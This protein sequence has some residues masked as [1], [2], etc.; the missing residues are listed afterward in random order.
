MEKTFDPRT[1]EPRWRRFWEEHAL[2]RADPVSSRPPFCMVIPPPNI[3]GRLHVGHGLNNTLQDVLARWKRMAG[4]DVL[5]VPGSD[6]ASIATHVMIE[7]ALEK[8]GVTRQQLGREAFLERA[9]AWK[10]KYGG[11]I[12]EQLRRLG[13]SCDW[14][15]E[16]FTMDPGLSRA[17]RE[18]FVRLYEEGLIY[19]DRYLINW[20]PK[21]RTAVSDL[22]VVHREAAGFM[23][24]VSYPLEG[25]GEIRVATTRP[26]TILG[27]VAVAVHPDDERYREVVGRQAILP[28]LGRRIP[29]VADSF[30]DPSFGTGAVKVTPGHDPNDFQ[31]GRRLGLEPIV[32]MD[33]SGRMT[34]EAGPFAGKDRFEC[35]DELLDRLRASGLLV[36]EKE[37]TLSIG[38]CQR[39]DTIVEPMISRQWFVRMEPLA[40]PALEAVERGDIAFVPDN[41]RKTYYEWMRNIRDWCISRQLWWGHRIPAWYCDSCSET[42]VSR[43]DPAACPGCGTAP[44]QDPDILDT[45]FSSGLWAFSTL[46]WPDETPELRRYYPTSVLVTGYDIIF[47]WVARMVMMGL[48]F[49]GEVPFRAVFYNGLVRDAKGEKISKTKGNVIDLF[50]LMDEYGTDPVRFTFAAMSSPGADVPLSP[51][52]LD[53]S[54]AFANKIWNA[55]RFARPHL[56]ASSGRTVPPRARLSVAD[57]WILSRGSRVADE[58]GRAL[59]AYRFDEAA[60]ALYQFTWHEVC[61]WYLELIKPALAE[62]G[63]AADAA[64]STLAHTLDRLLRLLH[65]FMPFL[66]EELWQ[67]LPRE[68]GD[69]VAVAVAAYPGREPALEDPEAERLAGTL[70]ETVTAARNLRATS[71]VP[72]GAKVR[73]LLRPLD[74]AARADLELLR[75]RIQGL[76]RAGTIEIVEALPPGLAAARAVTGPAEI[77][78]PLEGLLDLGAERARLGREMERLGKELAGH[79]AKLS[80]EQ[81]M[82]RAKPEA[83]EKVRLASREIADRLARLKETLAQLGS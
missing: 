4:H 42:I 40:R 31:A 16:R 25:G 83:V 2:F 27:D 36:E 22:E 55:V 58:A 24:T 12:T 75:E 28:V 21:C 7:R 41:W 59:E 43:E 47:F 78:L 15:R 49:R 3:T 52:R 82:S 19:R 44:R 23:W 38:R 6:H 66:T 8:E 45:W 79:E 61:D 67:G 20:C 81:F 46:G 76:A 73:L 35:R 80:N 54:R 11:E 14:S 64:R 57:R 13:A 74:N 17:V 39:C 65:P 70:M 53:G 60:A 9:W 69:P 33:E 18:V 32:V 62:G 5:W 72:A 56:E 50:D 37:H 10:E 71:N 63:A 26:E 1:V 34:A 51:G 48:K 30:V 77:A 29:V 68:A